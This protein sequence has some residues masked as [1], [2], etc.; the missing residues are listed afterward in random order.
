MAAR[1]N[2]RVQKLEYQKLEPRKL[3]TGDL[4]IPGAA[5]GGLGIDVPPAEIIG[6]HPIDSN[7]IIDPNVLTSAFTGV[8]SISIQ[9]GA[10]RSICTG[11]LISNHHV[12][13]AAH[14][15]TDDDGTSNANASQVRV[16]FNHDSDDEVIDAESLELHPD[17]NGFDESINDDLAVIELSEAAPVEAGIYPF[18]DQIPGLS[19]ASDVVLAG[20]GLTGSNNLLV[21]GTTSFTTK[22]VGFN[23]ASRFATDDEGSDLTEIFEVDFDFQGSGDLF[24]DGGAVSGCLLYTSPSPRDATL[25]R[26]PSSA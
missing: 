5:N 6:S 21:P 22:R 26:M 15:F 7:S 8:V 17:W 4:V 25:S 12:L 18:A 16:Y 24:N 9:R 3:L 14:C 1:T 19:G 23:V 2:K 20:Y 10:T 11:T 13:T